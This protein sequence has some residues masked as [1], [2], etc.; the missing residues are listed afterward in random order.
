MITLGLIAMPLVL[1]IAF[2]IYFFATEEKSK[3]IS[4]MPKMV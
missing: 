4:V 1:L 2:T 3:E